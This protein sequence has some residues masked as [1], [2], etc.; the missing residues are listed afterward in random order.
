MTEDEFSRRKRC[1]KC[2]QP[3]MENGVRPSQERH[4]KVLSMLC[5]NR[6]CV[7]FDTGWVISLN[8]DGSLPD[9]KTEAQVLAM[10]KAFPDLNPGTSNDEKEATAKAWANYMAGPVKKS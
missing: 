8:L 6:A 4:I 7:W 5:K 10:P 1:P 9:E 3:G 2:E